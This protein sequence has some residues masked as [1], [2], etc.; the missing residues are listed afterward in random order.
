MSIRQAESD[1]PGFRH[2]LLQR[3]LQVGVISSV[4]AQLAK[5]NLSEAGS[6]SATHVRGGRYGRGEVGE[7]VLIEGQTSLLLGRIVEVRLPDRDRRSINPSQSRFTELDA[8]GLIQLLGTVAMDSVQVTA[9]V[10]CYPRLGD[11]VYSAPHEFLSELPRLMET[12]GESVTVQLALGSID[13]AFESIVYVKPEK[14]FGRHCAILGATG[15]GKSWTTARVI[16]ECLKHKSKMILLDATGEYRGFTGDAV[17]HCHL[18]QPS[19]KADG[20]T[21]ASLPPMCFNE[22]DFIALFE[23]SGKVQGPKLRS[24]I[25]SLRLATLKP[26][27]ATNGVIRKIDQSKVSVVA[28][29]Q[30][31]GIAEKLEDPSQ[32]FDVTKLTAQIEQECVYP[33]GFGATRGTKDPNKWGGESGEF[34]YCLTL[35]SRI[36]GVLT[37]A[38]LECTFKHVEHPITEAIKQFLAAENKKLL[39]ICLSGVSSEY[40][41][42]E[43]VANAVGRHLLGLAR[44]G[45]MKERPVV[46]FVDEAHSFLGRHIGGDDTIARLDAFELIAKEGRKYGLNICLATQRPRD[47]TEGVL[48]QMGTLVVHRLTNDKD[49]EVVERACGEIDRSAA[50]FLPSLKPGEAAIVGADF[51]I[52]LTIQI[53]TPDAE[54]KSDGPRYQ[55]HWAT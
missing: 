19:E 42:R 9:G 28:A 17:T 33:E 5:F 8:I 23:P 47:I 52:P 40:K 7:F 37:S 22:S 51:P 15:G 36:S 38:S 45:A 46:V 53:A 39:R 32:P 20:S 43:I 29:E 54:P 44:G 18:G 30:E 21:Q 31:V 27:L 10:A 35:V 34:S 3:E 24:A 1:I 12:R 14:L 49:R 4:S 11:R 41:A 25:R 16:E 50:S 6:P 55:K 2:G 13:S 48:S 26:A